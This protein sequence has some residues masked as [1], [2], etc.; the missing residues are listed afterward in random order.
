M[1]LGDIKQVRHKF[2]GAAAPT[3][4]EDSGDGFSVGSFWFDTTNDKAYVCLDA[5]SAAAVWTELGAG[6]GGAWEIIE[7]IEASND[8]TVD[9]TSGIDSTYKA[10]ITLLEK[11]VPSNDNVNLHLRVSTNTG[12]S[13]HAG[14]SDYSHSRFVFSDGG[15]SVGGALG[16]SAIVLNGTSTWGSDTGEGGQGFVLVT[17]PSDTTIHTY[18][19]A[20]LTYNEPTAGRTG[21]AL[22]GG[23]YKSTT[24]IDGIRLYFSSGNIESGTFKLYGVK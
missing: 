3:A 13:W 14:A 16:A 2:D 7:T 24:A 19:T 15:S 12:S 21:Q 10:Y 23:K 6:G 1:A 20:R 8:A 22:S 18:V 11:V 5:A 9:F 4:D 17:S